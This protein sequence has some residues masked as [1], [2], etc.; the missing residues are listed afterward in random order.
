M[1]FIASFGGLAILGCGCFELRLVW[2]SSEFGSWAVLG[3][4]SW[5]PF[6]GIR[7]I[8]SEP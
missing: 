5:L 3:T 1:G 6:V 7:P 8:K 4:D 2:V